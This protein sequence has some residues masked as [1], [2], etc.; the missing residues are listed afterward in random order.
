MTFYL[1]LKVEKVLLYMIIPYTFFYTFINYVFQE[2][3][4]PLFLVFILL[5]AKNFLEKNQKFYILFHILLFFLSSYLYY[6][7]TL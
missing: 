7:I 4:D 2:Y 6:S 5:Y 3:L 1:A